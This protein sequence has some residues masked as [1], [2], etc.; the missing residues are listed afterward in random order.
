MPKGPGGKAFPTLGYGSL[1]DVRE[2]GKNKDLAWKL[3]AT[4]AGPDGNI[5]WNKKIGA[6]P[7]YK[8]A[9]KDPFYADPKFKGWF[10][11]LADKDVVPTVMPTYL[12]EFAFFADS[13]AVK[14]TQ[15][16]LLGQLTPQEMAA[17][18]AD[19]LTKAQQKFL[20]KK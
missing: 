8:T 20:A 10:D 12:E 13:I 3:I 9:E 15:Q 1:V 4:L 11:E 19:Y 2:F 17:Q 16:L 18:W 5:A 7:I 6:L 14:T